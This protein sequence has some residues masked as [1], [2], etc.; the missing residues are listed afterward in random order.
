M[1]DEYIVNLHKEIQFDL[2][3]WNKV[4]YLGEILYKSKNSMDNGD[5]DNWIETKLFISPK[6]AE[7][8]EF[9][10]QNRDMINQFTFKNTIPGNLPEMKKILVQAN[11]DFEAGK[12][13]QMQFG[14]FS[15][16]SDKIIDYINWIIQ[17]RGL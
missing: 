12:L 15:N 3:N 4:S 8:Y 14:R 6:Y 17:D 9:V 5:F 11:E 2:F 10:Y 7:F 13:D 1:D 16:V